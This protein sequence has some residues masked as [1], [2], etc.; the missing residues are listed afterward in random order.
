[1]KAIRQ[2]IATMLYAIFDVM[3][4]FVQYVLMGLP[5]LIAYAILEFDI[6][7]KTIGLLLF[8]ASFIGMYYVYEWLQTNGVVIDKWVRGKTRKIVVF[9]GGDDFLSKF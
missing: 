3:S 7:P 6:L 1:M 2:V 4:V 5:V 9:V 8:L